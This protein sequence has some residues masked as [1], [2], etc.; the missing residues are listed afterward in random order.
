[1]LP[2][3]IAGLINYLEPRLAADQAKPQFSIWDGE[4]PRWDAQ[5]NAVGPTNVTGSWPAVSL[6]IQEPGFQRNY[7]MADAI[8]DEGIIIVQAW[9][10]TREVTEEVLDFIIEQFEQQVSVYTDVDLGG[11]HNNPNYIIEMTVDTWWSGID[12]EYRTSNSQY[13]Y[14]G[15]VSF[16]TKIHGNATTAS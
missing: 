15:D 4:V 6:R 7:T 9:S 11:P 16:S 13:L 14:R 3:I 8:L 5:G 2:P 12:P 1:M 10:T